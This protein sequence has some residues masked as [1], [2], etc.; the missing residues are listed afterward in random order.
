MLIGLGAAFIDD[1]VSRASTRHVKGL[2][3]CGDILFLKTR[4]Y[5][6]FRGH[7]RISSDPYLKPVKLV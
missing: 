3:Q 5:V 2:V 6:F 1:D 4:E 7:G